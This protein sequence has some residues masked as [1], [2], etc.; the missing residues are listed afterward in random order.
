MKKLPNKDVAI[1]IYNK[2]LKSGKLKRQSCE[3]CGKKKTDG[4]HPDYNYPL[5]VMWL[6]KKHHKRWHHEN[7]YQ[8]VSG[9]SSKLINIKTVPQTDTGDQVE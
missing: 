7:G 2:A 9:D 5:K 1:S 3:V 4:H 8:Q 6:C